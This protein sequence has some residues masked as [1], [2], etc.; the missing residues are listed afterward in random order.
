VAT[1][2]AM[3]YRVA[4]FFHFAHGLA[5]AI[6]P[7]CLLFLVTH[8]YSFVPS[9][10]I[11][12][13]CSGLF[14][15]ATHWSIYRSVTRNGLS[16]LA[17]LIASL[18]VYVAGQNIISIIWGD[19]PITPM[20][21]LLSGNLM[22][23]GCRITRTNSLSLIFAFF[24][25]FL[26]GPVL[27][28]TRLGKSMRAIASNRRLSIELGIRTERVMI[29]TYF[30]ASA[31]AGLGGIMIA[32]DTSARPTMGIEALLPG[33]VA[34]VLGGNRGIGGVLFAS[35]LLAMATHLGVIY[36]SSQWQQSIVFVVLLVFLLF[37][38][39]VQCPQ[40][41]PPNRSS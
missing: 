27:S 32:Y 9:L 11:A 12:L 28:A 21:D 15:V 8:G 34:V 25:V 40:I 18:G 3:I 1:S 29:L 2:F 4:G 30:F 10:V 19:D 7:Y 23:F 5:I 39:Y 33:V 41:I 31:I 35:F 6:G 16:P 20:Q 37:R 24:V 22:I 14:G 13:I 36:I 26:A 17:L 38:A